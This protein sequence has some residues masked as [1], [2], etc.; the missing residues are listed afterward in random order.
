MARGQVVSFQTFVLNFV[1]PLFVFRPPEDLS[2]CV[3]TSQPPEEHEAAG[4]DGSGGITAGVSSAST[5]TAVASVTTPSSGA[6][7]PP[8][9]TPLLTDA[10][11]EERV[12]IRSRRRRKEPEDTRDAPPSRG[13]DELEGK[14][15]LL[16]QEKTFV[17]FKNFNWI[18]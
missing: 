6:V 14:F 1:L 2:N 5:T 8:V 11:N 7:I 18:Y 9:L 3:S 15:A 13:L 17:Y 16:L 4:L 10:W 12:E